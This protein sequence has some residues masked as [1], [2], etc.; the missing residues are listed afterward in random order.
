MACTVKQITATT[1]S[2]LGNASSINVATICRQKPMMPHTDSPMPIKRYFLF[3]CLPPYAYP[4][5][6][7]EVT[8]PKSTESTNS[9]MP[10]LHSH[11]IT[12]ADCCQRKKGREPVRL[13]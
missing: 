3:I 5:T 12:P 8:A 1:R 6:F 13:I 4:E 11:F 9:T 7:T 2:E 10:A